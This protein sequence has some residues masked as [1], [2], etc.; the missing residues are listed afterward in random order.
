MKD[1]DL[2]EKKTLFVFNQSVHS[3]FTAEW[4]V[5]HI[6]VSSEVSCPPQQAGVSHTVHSTTLGVPLG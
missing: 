5:T 6:L 1:S 3:G 4:G 2:S